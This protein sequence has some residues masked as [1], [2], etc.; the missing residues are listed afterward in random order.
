[1]GGPCSTYGAKRSA[2]AVFWWE[3]QKEDLDVGGS[4]ILK[5]ILKRNMLGRY[6]LDYS[7]SGWG[8]VTHSCEHGNEPSGSI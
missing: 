2:Y 6:G 3:S 1:M 8:T 7:G 4:M 5:W